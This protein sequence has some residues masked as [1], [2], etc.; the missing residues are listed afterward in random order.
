MPSF[1]MRLAD[2]VVAVE[3]LLA[4]GVVAVEVED[5]ET[6]GVVESEIR[7]TVPGRRTM[8]VVEDLAV[9]EAEA[10]SDISTRLGDGFRGRFEN[11]QP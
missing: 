10:E 6:L 8:E 5:E 2:H 9:V 11:F 7:R 3:D 4:C 1:W